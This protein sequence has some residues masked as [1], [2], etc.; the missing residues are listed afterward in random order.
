MR[1]ALRLARECP[2]LPYP[3]PWVGCVIVR[4]GRVVGKGFHHGAG[5]NHAEV[6]ALL[7]AGP[8]ARGA[9]L[10]VTLEP[11]CHYGR[12]PPCTDAIL[13]AGIRE[14]YY[15]M[16]DPN[17]VVSGRS[18]RLLA[19]HGLRVHGGLCSG[20]A[21]LLNEMYVKLR[22]T[23]M[24]FVTVKAA[25]SLDG[26]IATRAG[27]S[28]WVTDKDARRRARLLR[29]E[30]QAVMVGINT[31][32]SDDPHLGPRQHGAAEPWRIVL[33]SRLR[34]PLDS[35]VVK[36]GK[37]IVACTAGASSAKKARLEHAGVRVLT[38]R[39][40]QV[41]LRALLRHLANEEI[42]SLLVEG[43]GE[44]LGSFFDLRLVNRVC[45]FL[46]PL[47]LGSVRSRAAVAGMGVARIEQACRLQ[48]VKMEQVGSAWLLQGRP[49]WPR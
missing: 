5:T 28:K 7:D 26:K 9:T 42:I 22:S 17:P 27:Q 33:D 16:K 41:P 44:V 39:G 14:V 4:D 15:A 13:K 30:H 21:T 12:T 24:P 31:V 45:W 25:T 23:G 19:K 47:V 6:E 32:L 48:D 37:C 34:I 8:R 36:S 20:E 1:A 35:K 40:K 38:F 10:Y 29:T 46:S 11:C 2:G 49:R 3:N 43:G 18:A